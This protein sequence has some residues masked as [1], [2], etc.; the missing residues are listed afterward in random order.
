MQN[1]NTTPFLLTSRDNPDKAKFPKYMVQEGDNP[2]GRISRR[3]LANTSFFTFDE[4]KRVAFDTRVLMADEY[5]PQFLS[6][7]KAGF[8]ISRNLPADKPSLINQAVTFR[9]TETDEMVRSA[10]EELSRWDH[11]ATTESVAMTVFSA[12]RERINSSRA[13]TPLTRSK[14]LSEALENLSSQHGTWRVPWGEINRLQRRDESTQED[15]SDARTSLPTPGVNGAD[16]AVYTFYARPV[17][18]QKR[19]YGVAGATYVSVVEFGPQVR[20]LSIHVFGASGDPKSRHYMDQAELYSRG[21]FKPAWFTLRE[22]RA[23]L[24]AAYHPGER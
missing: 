18:G 15:F 22:I 3:I 17:T 16:G 7:L 4:W 8:G 13:Q 11:K 10:Y 21:E 5:L 6:E 9:F 23:N 12:W 19:R 20:A 24:E 1:C 2:R 14:A